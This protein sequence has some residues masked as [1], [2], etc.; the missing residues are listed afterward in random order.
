QHIRTALR[1]CREQHS[2]S[3]FAFSPAVRPSGVGKIM[4]FWT[5]EHPS[6]TLAVMEPATRRRK[7]YGELHGDVSRIF[8]P[9]QRS[10][11]LLLAQNR[12]ECLL[13][14]LAALRSGNPLLLVDASL[15]RELLQ[16]LVDAYRPAYIYPPLPGLKVS[17]Y[18]ARQE[19]GLGVWER[20]SKDSIA[21]HE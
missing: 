5:I 6:E 18:E 1:D 3:Q 2:A 16:H 7:T 10:L 11:L 19:G 4:D 9:K 13:T 20:Q 8:M 15:N 12:Y 21:I 14:Y 17:G